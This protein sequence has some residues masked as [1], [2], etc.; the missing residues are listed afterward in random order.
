M[1]ALK[2]LLFRIYIYDIPAFVVSVNERREKGEK[3][4]T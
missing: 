4:H 2:R 1:F 3:E